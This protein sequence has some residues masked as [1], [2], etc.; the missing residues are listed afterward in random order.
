MNKPPDIIVN[1]VLDESYSMSSRRVE[2][3]SAVNEYIGGLRADAKEKEQN[4][5]FSFTLFN[6]STRVVH[7]AEDIQNVPD[8]TEETYAPDGGTALL[9]AIGLT[10]ETVASKVDEH[11][12]RPAILCVIM[13]DGDENSSSKFSNEDIQKLIAEKEKEGN[14]TFVYLGA[15]K[16]AWNK[17]VSYGFSKGHS[18][19]YDTRNM[20][21]TMSALRC[22]TSQYMGSID[23]EEGILG[24]A[25]FFAGADDALIRGI[26]LDDEE[27]NKD[28]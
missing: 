4:V 16:E 26:D 3:I 15:D 10:V 11:K 24:S 22:S 13:T 19:G 7:A 5:L 9:D 6:T 14:W 18:V 2:T 20:V 27:S 23:A 17:G 25:D 8:I 28:D 1:F 12:W 21:K